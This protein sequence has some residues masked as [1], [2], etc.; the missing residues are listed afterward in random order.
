MSPELAARVEASLRGRRVPPRAR[1]EARSISLLRLAIVAGLSLLIGSA[2]LSWRRANR[3]LAERRSA[4]VERIER[5]VASFGPRHREIPERAR[6]VLARSSGDYEGDFVADELRA[7][8]ALAATLRRP[9]LYL[10][11]TQEMLRTRA[12]LAHSAAASAKDAF[13]LCLLDPPSTRSEKALLGRTRQAYALGSRMREATPHVHRL[14]PILVTLPLLDPAWKER[15]LTASPYELDDRERELERA[16]LGPAKSAGQ[17]ELFL[18]LID[19]P[20]DTSG[21]TELDGERPHPIR[22]GLVDLT[23]DRLLLRLRRRVDPRWL[24]ETVRAEYARGIDSCSLA[25]DV[26]AALEVSGA[27][28][29]NDRAANDR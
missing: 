24:S 7:P 27:R 3:E 20:A 6:A 15:V 8:G 28:A 12:G 2:I 9:T 25:L 1:L 23:A 5:E 4:L 19:E 16:P 10:R 18:F 29:A 14:H 22:V 17:A 13:V 11:G 26:R 21:P